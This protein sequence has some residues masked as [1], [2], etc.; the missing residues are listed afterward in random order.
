M[1]RDVVRQ[2]QYGRLAIAHEIARHGEDEVGVGA[3]HLGQE[4]LDPLHRDLGPALDQFRTLNHPSHRARLRPSQA[5]RT[6]E[7]ERL[8]VSLTNPLYDLSGTHVG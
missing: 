5:Y 7:L 3:E 8:L 4:L 2:D 6:N 1:R